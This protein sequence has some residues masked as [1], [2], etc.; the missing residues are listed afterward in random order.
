M[1]VG[2]RFK[3]QVA[4]GALDERVEKFAGKAHRAT[5]EDVGSSYYSAARPTE[6]P[7]VCRKAA[8][9]A[10]RSAHEVCIAELLALA[11]EIV[12]TGE[13]GDA[14]DTSMIRVI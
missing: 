3:R 5:A 13:Q 2:R 6:S 7:M 4:K 10:A 12:A 8:D 1:Q 11:N 14:V 9:E